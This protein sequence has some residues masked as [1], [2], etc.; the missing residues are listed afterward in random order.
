MAAKIR[1]RRIGTRKKPIYRL[2]VA[3]ESAPQQGNVI[4]V[5]GLYNPRVEPSLFEMKTERVQDWLSKGAT[6]TESVRRL[7]GNVGLLP[8]VI[9]K[10]KPQ[11]AAPEAAE[12]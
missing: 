7:L 9:Y 3:D 5:V 2:V 12:V 4:E 11:K 1:F 10:P 6:P 8:K